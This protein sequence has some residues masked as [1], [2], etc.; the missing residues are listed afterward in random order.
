MRWFLQADEE[1]LRELCDRALGEGIDLGVQELPPEATPSRARVRLR[2]ESR[3]EVILSLHGER[4]WRYAGRIGSMRLW[5]A[6]AELRFLSR[7]E[8]CRWI[9]G[10]L[11]Q[12]LGESRPGSVVVAAPSSSR[13]ADFGLGHASSHW[14]AM[15]AEAEL[16][17]SRQS[18]NQAVV[19]V[20][21]SGVGKTE[22]LRQT[23]DRWK[24]RNPE[25]LS[26]PLLYAG[27]AFS[28]VERLRLLRRID[29]QAGGDCLAPPLILLEDLPCVCGWPALDF[30]RRRPRTRFRPDPI[31]TAVLSAAIDGG[32]RLCATA[33]PCGAAVLRQPGLCARLHWIR[34]SAPDLDTLRYD[35]LPQA[36]RKLS[37]QYG[38]D[39]ADEC[40][41]MALQASS[42]K[43]H[44]PGAA[45]CVLRRSAVRAAA[46]GLSVLGPDDVY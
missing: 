32:L 22:F 34:L 36:A 45:I 9:E 16:V 1:Q 23:A 43:G 3:G 35:V 41:A 26:A 40:L 10:D 24:R 44:Q 33:S 2:V 5:F 29:R 13:V 46:R 17:L 21:P 30:G 28:P 6:E 38:I 15:L 20:G 8:F 27:R 19:V 25:A 42:R 14:S 4:E 37:R 18:G 11:K 7:A 12:A 31:G 39:V